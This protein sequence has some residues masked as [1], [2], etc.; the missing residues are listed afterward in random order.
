[1][2]LVRHLLSLSLV[3]IWFCS[4]VVAGE[5]ETNLAHR[6][7]GSPGDEKIRVWIET[8]TTHQVAD[9]KAQVSSAATQTEKHAVAINA[10]KSRR[11]EQSAVLTALDNL[12]ARGRAERVMGHWIVNVVE[13]TVAAS[14]LAELAKRSDIVAIYEEP[15][16]T[17][18]EPL[19]YDTVYTA[20]NDATGVASNI[21]QVRADDAW[22]I[23][24]YDGTGRLVCSFDTGVNGNHPALYSRWKGLDGDSAAAWFDPVFKQKF[25]HAITSIGGVVPYHGT[26]TMGIICGADPLPTFDTVGVAPGAKWISAAVI[27]IPGASILEAFEWA[28]D[29]DGNPNTVDDVPDVINHS[30]GFTNVSCLDVFYTAIDNVEALG[31]VNIFSAGNEGTAGPRAPADRALDSLDCFAVGNLDHVSDLIAG[32]SAKGPSPCN[33]LMIK[34]NVVAPGTSILSTDYFLDAD[35]YRTVSG[36]SQAAPHVSGLVALMRQKNPNATVDQIKS[37]ILLGRRSTYPIS[38][39]T[40]PNNNYGYGEIDCFTA[41]AFLP[42]TSVAPN[43]RLYDFDYPPVAAGGTVVGK[44]VLQNLGADEQNVTATVL[45]TNPALSIISGNLTFGNINAGDTVRSGNSITVVIADTVTE[46]SILSADMAIN[47]DQTSGTIRLHFLVGDP[48]GR[49]MATH[50]G[51]RIEF[52]LSD[53]GV[54]GFGSGS[55]FPVNGAGFE[56]D[57]G[58]NDLWEG[59]L[60]VGNAFYRVSSGVHSYLFDPDLDFKVAP[61]GNIEYIAPGPIS[62]QQTWAQFDDS[63]A[64]DPIGL[65]FTQE[66]FLYGPPNDDILVLRYIFKNVSGGSLANLYV[67]LFMDFDLPILQYN[68]DAGGYDTDDQFL[69]MAYNSSGTLSRYRGIKL[70]QGN[71]GAAGAF[72]AS[73]Y[74]HYPPISLDPGNGLTTDEKY[75]ALTS[76]MLYANV[77]KTAS[78]DLF[79]VMSAG[80]ISMAVNDL[81]TVTFAL[82]GGELL[83]EIRDAAQRAELVPTP[84]EPDDPGVILPESYVL[85][86][87]YPNP[88]NPS[89]VI[90]FDLPRRGEYRLE[91]IN[92]LGQTVYV[93][94]DVTG[95]GRVGVEWN[96]EGFASGAYFYR[97]TAGEYTQTRKMMLLK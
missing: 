8:S 12:Q 88:F 59:G 85:Y 70:L 78:D 41:L 3:T 18:I 65:L 60:M 45:G 75:D 94:S 51:S 39:G 22:Y 40:L 2:N 21:E 80:P 92:V 30:W 86:Q 5:L 84:V 44:V 46:G 83:P 63:N 49:S 10:L 82:F 7:A 69:W 73:V 19:S 57:G 76:G 55:T 16:P 35:P 1:M 27:D 68:S 53:Y 90:R 9:L 36:T 48:P 66:S 50:V 96:G 58:G 37:T 87:N 28:A 13:A 54:F 67:G 52:S 62:P 74:N 33:V 20:P 95:P 32:T 14:D 97:L 15:I 61:S 89:T 17:I 93:A 72:G 81:D 71:L 6:V 91:I 34:P 29:P 24:G 77:N 26:H 64:D 4:T 38:W 42:A 79:L 47:G 56:F 25:P 43:I 31:I 23:A 11:T